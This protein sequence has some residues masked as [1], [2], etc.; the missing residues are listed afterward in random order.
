M[1]LI[2]KFVYG[3]DASSDCDKCG[4]GLPRVVIE[5]LA[6]EN[7]HI[8]LCEECAADLVMAD[9]GVLEDAVSLF[10]EELPVAA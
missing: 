7:Q 4:A 9:D 5:D 10:L 8:Y 2:R 6:K 3:L 1:T